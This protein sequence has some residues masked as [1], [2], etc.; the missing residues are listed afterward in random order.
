MHGM[1]H[2]KIICEKFRETFKSG[3]YSLQIQ[4]WTYILL[5][6]VTGL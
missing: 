6:I 1:S 3:L 2:I 4:V 5:V